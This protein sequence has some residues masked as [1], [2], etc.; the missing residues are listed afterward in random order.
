M[1]TVLPTADALVSV[2]VGDH[3]LASTSRRDG[4]WVEMST[5]P[6]T[7]K[8]SLAETLAERGWSTLDCPISGAR[9]QLEAGEAVLLSSGQRDT[10]DRVEQVLRAISPRV[11]YIGAR[12]GPNRGSHELLSH[13]SAPHGSRR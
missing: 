7:V 6:E 10:H 1:I 11:S 4:I 5:V 9:D 2:T 3:G 13:P 8:R 12:P